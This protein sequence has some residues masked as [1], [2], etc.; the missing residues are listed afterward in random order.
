MASV[1]DFAMT[2]QSLAAIRLPVRIVVGK[3]EDH[4]VPSADAEPLAAHIPGATLEVLSRGSHYA[5]LPLCSARGKQFAKEICVDA[6][7]IDRA[8]I[9]AKAS[10]DALAFF[11][12]MGH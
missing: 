2:A 10:A 4:S 12:Q 3:D 9:H 11:Q 8:A 5:F 6:P 1:A 7:G